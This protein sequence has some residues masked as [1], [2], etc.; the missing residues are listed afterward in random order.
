VLAARHRRHAR[1][2]ST[3][4][5]SDCSTLCDLVVGFKFERGRR[6]G[7]FPVVVAPRS[8]ICQFRDCGKDG[9]KRHGATSA[10]ESERASLRAA[11]SGR[12]PSRSAGVHGRST[13]VPARRPLAHAGAARSKRGRVRQGMP[14]KPEVPLRRTPYRSHATAADRPEA[15][16]RNK[17]NGRCV[18]QGVSR[19]IR[20]TVQARPGAFGQSRRRVWRVRRPIIGLAGVADARA[21]GPGDGTAT[22]IAQAA[23]LDRHRHIRVD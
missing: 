14:A 6:R 12:G 4:F 15:D 20:T 17:G 5:T 16:G 19:L 23:L 18:V 13:G 3:R 7:R 10:N 21:G 1:G 22:S 8:S 9:L 2:W 11:G